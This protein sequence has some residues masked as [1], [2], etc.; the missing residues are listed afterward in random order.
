MPQ[1]SR[2]PPSAAS[3]ASFLYHFVQ[4]GRS[5]AGQGWSRR[6]PKSLQAMALPA[7]GMR[8]NFLRFLK[9]KRAEA[10]GGVKP[11]PGTRSLRRWP[12]TR[13]SSASCAIWRDR[14]ESFDL[15]RAL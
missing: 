4:G 14:D 13:L 10:A 8:D 6:K 15:M 3:C 11:G 7:S 12:R 5:G 2:S 1:T 9:Q